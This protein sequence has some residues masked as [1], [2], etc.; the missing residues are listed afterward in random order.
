MSKLTVT[1]IIKKYQNWRSQ[2]LDKGSFKFL[3]IGFLIVGG[4]ILFPNSIIATTENP[5]LLSYFTWIPK[6]KILGAIVSGLSI[7]LIEIFIIIFSAMVF[8][9]IL[10]RLYPIPLDME[11]VARNTITFIY[12]IIIVV[13]CIITLAIKY[14][15]VTTSNI[16][17]LI[18]LPFELSLT[19]TAIYHLNTHKVIEYPTIL[20]LRKFKSGKKEKFLGPLLKITP[21]HMFLSFLVSTIYNPLKWD[22]LNLAYPGLIM[23]KFPY[24]NSPAVFYTCLNHKWEDVADW[25]IHKAKIIIIDLS[26]FSEAVFNETLMAI[27]AKGV[28]D[29]SVILIA[30]QSNYDVSNFPYII[31]IYTKINPV[32]MCRFKGKGKGKADLFYIIYTVFI[33]SWLVSYIF[34]YDII[35]VNILNVS[36]VFI[37]WCIN[38]VLL[39][40]WRNQLVLT[41]DSEKELSQRIKDS[42]VK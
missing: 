37:S 8:K 38:T 24:F 33:F 23:K 13:L 1:E 15:I 18:I 28:N 39:I 31:N 2:H 25:L 36:V 29:K 5:L 21:P 42:L 41:S 40:I 6:I 4:G 16:N 27:R 14:W 32:I 34:S 9:R 35:Q 17:F 11:G 12:L 3:I 10:L 19:A 26:I 30:D 20:F 22:F 7:P